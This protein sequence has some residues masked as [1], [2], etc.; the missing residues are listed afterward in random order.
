MA[1]RLIATVTEFTV[2]STG[3]STVLLPYRPPVILPRLSLP[4]RVCH[5]C[6]LAGHSTP[7]PLALLPLFTLFS[8]F[9]STVSSMAVS[10]NRASNGTL[11]ARLEDIKRE[12]QEGNLPLNKISN[13]Y[14]SASYVA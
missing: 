1:R 11:E 3:H 2:T 8:L 14:G 6:S 10:S 9:H 5:F 4:P 13:Q 12:F 7:V